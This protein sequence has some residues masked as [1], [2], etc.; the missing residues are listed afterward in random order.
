MMLILIFILGLFF[1]ACIGL[2]VA[3][4]CVAASRGDAHLATV[5][6]EEGSNAPP[7]L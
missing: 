1:G 2:V 6:Q 3:G 4:L 7:A 5:E